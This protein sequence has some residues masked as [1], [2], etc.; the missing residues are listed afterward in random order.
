MRETDTHCSNIEW[1]AAHQRVAGPVIWIRGW[2]VGRPG[3]AYIDVRIQHCGQT[4]LGVLGLPRTDLAAHFSS[5]RP[6]LPAEFVIGVP[7]AD[8]PAELRIEAMNED[9]NWHEVQQLA[10][11]VA[12]DGA[13]SP[14]VEGQLVHRPE[15]TWTIRG[16]HAPFHGHLDDP[17]LA[18]LI[19]HGRTPVFGW[20]LHEHQPLQ[21]VLATTDTLIFN[22]LEHSLTDESLA[23]KVPEQPTARQAR[24]QGDVE[25][26][27]TLLSPACLRVY[28]QAADGT[29]HLCFAQRLQLT[30]APLTPPAEPATYREE[31]ARPLSTYPSGRPRRLLIVTRSLQSDDATLRA[32]DLARHLI[33]SGRWAARLVSAEDGPLRADF[34][35]AGIESLIVDPQKIFNATDSAALSTARTQLEREILWSHLDAVAVFD[36]LCFWAIAA[37]RDRHIPVLFDCSA[38][39]PMRPDP[40]TTSV[41]QDFIRQAWTAP[42]RLC[43]ASH[44]AARAQH[45]A[46]AGNIAEIIPQWHPLDR[47]DPVARD[48]NHSLALAPLRTAD[49]LIRRHPATAAHWR[50]HRPPANSSRHERLAQQDDTWHYPNLMQAGPL[51]ITQLTLCLGASRPGGG[52]RDLLDAAANGI[53]IVTPRTPLIAEFFNAAEISFVA[54]NNPMALAHAVIAYE[55]NPTAF[56]ERAHRAQQRIRADY[57]PTSGLARWQTLLETV[58]ATRG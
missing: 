54:D 50:F 2:V 26:P 1:P 34:W 17:I 36:P 21:A 24:V 16:T 40:Q 38:H 35:H 11:T 53:P 49:W 19:H 12:A 4:H 58:A 22:H 10:L 29:V 30:P 5:P 56:T 44:V 27:A 32:L 8:G 15:G 23:A 39:E 52:I 28:G 20:L 3:H 48:K 37:A 55:T 41:V 33:G 25:V 14:R 46:L 9:G 57:A 42:T 7:L 51:E 31:P 47:L 45:G 6:W 43:F 18:P 13:A